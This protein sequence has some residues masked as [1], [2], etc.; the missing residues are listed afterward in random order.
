[1]TD[2]PKDEREAVEGTL[3]LCGC[4]FDVNGTWFTICTKHQKALSDYL[5]LAQ[6]TFK[7]QVLE[8]AQPSPRLLS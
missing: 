8:S 2:E 6:E 3:V 7:L 1:M 5:R 4:G